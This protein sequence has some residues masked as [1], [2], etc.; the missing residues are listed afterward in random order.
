[1]LTR[2]AAGRPPRALSAALALPA[3]AAFALLARRLW[4]FTVDDTFITLRYARHLAA[5]IGLT[6]NV[7]QP[8]AEGYTSLA[9]TVLMAIPHLLRTDAEAFAKSLG[10]A[11]TLLTALVASRWA[12]HA[13]HGDGG[14]VFAAVAA[15]LVFLALPATAVH[16][17]SGMETALATLLLT[18][19]LAL[20]GAASAGNPRA[21]ALLPP[22]ATLLAL[23]RPEGVLAG[24]VAIASVAWL[25]PAT[26][27]ALARATLVA[28]VLPLAAWEA[29]RLAY[30]RLPLPLPFYVKLAHPGHLAGAPVVGRWLADHAWRIGVFVVVAAVRPRRSLVPAL[31]VTAALALFFTLPQHLMGY[32][33]RYVAPCD[34][35]LAVLSAVGLD[36]VLRGAAARGFPARA[37]LAGGAAVLVLVAAGE[38]TDA[39]VDVPERLDYAAGMHA[40]HLPLAHALAAL[41]PDG[42]IALSDAGSVPY[43]TDWRALDLVGLDDPVIATTHRRDPARVLA[44]RPDVIACVSRHAA[45]FVAWDWNAYETPLLESAYGAGY[46]RFATLRFGDDYWLWVLALPGSRA[47]HAVAA[48]R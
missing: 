7:A 6:Y 27:R 20:A 11:L 30:Y 36:R 5:G 23:A 48:L 37:L 12:S 13:A 16:A 45:R 38:L 35:T 25:A 14:R 33:H 3:L 21:T 47:A 15:P 32:Q 43:F 42:T 46:R 2:T 40:A 41:G 17:V 26:R 8:H 28:F 34:A 1:M 4:P 9:W 29:A 24:A 22:F 31:A 19:L 39:R 44:M 10:L 18:L